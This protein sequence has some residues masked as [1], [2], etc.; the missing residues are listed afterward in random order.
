VLLSPG[1]RVPVGWVALIF[2]IRAEERML[3]RDVAWGTYVAAVRYCLLPG[4]W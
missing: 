1:A 3:A 4:V 2:R